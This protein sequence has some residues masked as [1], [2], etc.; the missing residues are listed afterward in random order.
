MAQSR[1]RED[2][3]TYF[4]GAS[5]SVRCG[6]AGA[7]G[8]RKTLPPPPPLRPS[9]RLALLLHL[10]SQPLS[11]LFC[12]APGPPPRMLQGPSLVCPVFLS[13]ALCFCT[14]FLPRYSLHVLTGGSCLFSTSLFIR[15]V[16]GNSH[17][18]RAHGSLATPPFSLWI[19]CAVVLALRNLKDR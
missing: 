15:I 4:A 7:G 16:L 2:A 19:L 11:S 10:P 3:S 14:L 9:C 12:P 8:F 13:S 18:L 17:D 6:I 5:L 1:E